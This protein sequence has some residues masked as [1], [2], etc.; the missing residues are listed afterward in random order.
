LTKRNICHTVQVVPKTIDTNVKQFRE[1]R[2]WTVDE[3]AERAGIAPRTVARIEAGHDAQV[4]T[5]IAVAE[6]LGTTLDALRATD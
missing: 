2:G 1:R 5:F 6:A 3:L 4:S